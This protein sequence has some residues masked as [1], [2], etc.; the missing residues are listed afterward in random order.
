MSEVFSKSNQRSQYPEYNALVR[1]VKKSFRKKRAKQLAAG[2]GN[3]EEK[4][5]Q[6]TETIIS[7]VN[8]IQ[9]RYGYQQILEQP[10]TELTALPDGTLLVNFPFEAMYTE[11]T[12]ER[13][14]RRVIRASGVCEDQAAIVSMLANATGVYGETP[15]MRPQQYVAQNY[16]HIRATVSDP[17]LLGTIPRRPIDTSSIGRRIS[18]ATDAYNPLALPVVHRVENVIRNGEEVSEERGILVLRGRVDEENTFVTKRPDGTFDVH[19]GAF[20]GTIVGEEMSGPIVF[21][22]FVRDSHTFLVI[23]TPR[24]NERYIIAVNQETGEKQIIDS[25]KIGT[26]RKLGQFIEQKLHMF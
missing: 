9:F 10:T 15:L 22:S 6:N 18:E 1:D 20:Q 8:S 16:R 25:D 3:V 13:T 23:G 19:V 26:C 12:D 4:K 14:N 17:S 21:S 2:S 24:V 5:R 7:L 11:A